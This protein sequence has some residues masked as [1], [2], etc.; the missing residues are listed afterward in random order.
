MSEQGLQQA[1][2]KMAAAGVDPVAIEVFSHYYRLVES[3]ETGMVPESTIEPVEISSID[4]VDVATPAPTRGLAGTV[5]VKLNGG[6]G[7]SMGLDRAK[8]LLEVR[9]GL[10]FLD[11]IVRQVL[12]A[13]VAHDVALPL[14]FMNSFRTSADTGALL[15]GY[16]GLGVDGLPV[17]FL[18]NKEP[19][20]RADDLT[21]V[22]W[23]AD[24]SLEWC[25][26]GHGDIYTAM[27]GT[28][29]LDALIAAGYERAFVSN[30]DNLGA[31]PDARVAEWFAASGA[32]FAIEAVR[33]TPSDR[34]GGHFARR[35]S[36]GRIVLRE[37]AQTLDED[38]QALADLGRHKYAS[39]NNLWFDLVAMREALDSRD[40]ILG[41][42]MI[43]NTKTVDP[44]DPSSPEVVQIETAMGAAIE[45][46]D[47]AELI[48][49]S[50]E[51]F[52]PVKTTNDLLVLRSDCYRLA[53]DSSLELTS[54]QVPFVDLDPRFY[55]LVRDFD[56][57]FPDGFPSMRGATSLTV[58]G[59]W[60]FGAGVTVLGEAILSEQD[61]PGRVE[62]GTTIG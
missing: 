44:A 41:L 37:S 33:R 13:R 14:V 62:A 59:D 36:D 21:P 4:D 31:V 3:G 56:A 10:T 24:P 39:T 12:A 60:T 17:E 27:R 38:K 46:F 52:V 48:E 55:K 29:L 28:G 34:K 45:V 58:K 2:D 43:K 32:P 53:E 11:L 47:G 9:D 15:E 8:S 22:S 35:R 6:L 40:G 18:Q 7:T 5:V 20:L 16:A 57:R 30:S 51:R 61:G 49:V 1:R 42:A 23:P 54:P 19:K 25:P 50:R 26:P